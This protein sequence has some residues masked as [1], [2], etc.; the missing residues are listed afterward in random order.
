MGANRI[1]VPGRRSLVPKF[2]T[3]ADTR[4][5]HVS[6]TNGVTFPF[7]GK[8]KMLPFKEKLIVAFPGKFMFVWSEQTLF[9]Y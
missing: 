3:R 9:S 2:A 6:M 5:R 8:V 1:E 4:E 7:K